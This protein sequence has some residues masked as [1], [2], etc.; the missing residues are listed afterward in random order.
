[1][2]CRDCRYFDHRFTDKNG[3]QAGMCRAWGFSINENDD[4]GCKEKEPKS[5]GE[6]IQPTVDAAQVVRCEDCTLRGTERC[7][8]Y[9]A[10]DD[11]DCCSDDDT[12]NGGDDA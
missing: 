5:G 12:M 1:M 8:W 9:D 4:R 7:L 3:Q 10:D 6:E 11:L 2:S